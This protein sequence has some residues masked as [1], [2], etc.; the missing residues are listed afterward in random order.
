MKLFSVLEKIGILAS[1]AMCL[2]AASWM[3][4]ANAASQNS[5]I[6]QQM[7]NSN[8]DGSNPSKS[9]NPP[10]KPPPKPGPRDGGADD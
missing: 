3:S 4:V 10:P 1:C 9:D 5:T 6:T 2:T 8:S 7:D